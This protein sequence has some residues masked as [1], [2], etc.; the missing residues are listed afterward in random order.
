MKVLAHQSGVTKGSAPARTFTGRRS[1]TPPAAT[2][3]PSPRR[4][5]HSRP[6]RSPRPRPPPERIGRRPGEKGTSFRSEPGSGLVFRGRRGGFGW[7]SR[8]G[9]RSEEWAAATEAA[10]EAATLGLGRGLR[11]GCARPRGLGRRG[12]AFLGLV[13]GL[14]PTRLLARKADL[15]LAAVN[16]EDLDLDLV[17]DVDDF[18][19]AVDLVV[20]QLRDVQQALKAGLKLDKDAEVGQ[21]GDLAG[22]HVARLVPARDIRLP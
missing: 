2:G 19:G 16:T 17:A 20:G 18:L 22:D 1:P 14:G 6:P 13:L 10:L 9:G 11:L 5:R 4:V 7:L 8:F 15:P 12:C 21:L 3:H